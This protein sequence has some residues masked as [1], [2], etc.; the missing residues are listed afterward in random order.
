[1]VISLEMEL[2][3]VL[4]GWVVP[5]LLG[6]FLLLI[7]TPE[8]HDQVYYEN[9]KRTCATVFLLFGVEILCQWLMR[10][11]EINNPILSVST[12]LFTFCLATQLLAMGYCAM[13]WPNSIDKRQQGI[14]V[15]TLMTFTS[16]LVI[17]YFLLP[18]RWQVWGLML[19]CVLLFFLT[20]CAIYSCVVIYRR[21]IKNLRTYYS[22]VVENMIRWMPGV[23]AGILIFLLSAPFIIWLPR[24]V[25]VYQ[26]TLG[27]IM[28]I[29]TFIC[30]LNFSSTYRS[31]A[32]ARDENA[33]AVEEEM[34]AAGDDEEVQASS[35]HSTLSDS[36]LE[37]LQVKEERW[38]AL[39][40]YR[41]C[42][43]TIEQAARE[44]GT[45][46]SYLSRY[47]NEVKHMTF[48]EWVAQ[49][50]IRDAQSMMLN[51]PN[52]SIEQIAGLVGFSS[53]STFS[54]TFKKLVG[55]SPNRWRNQQ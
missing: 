51:N 32:V 12:Y 41:T 52:K 19:C 28:F 30:M 33:M 31:L 18:R 11:L 44:M 35:Q 27:I 40:G 9:G 22:D 23:G 37:V 14:A 45:N 43:I 5:L 10:K 17:N 13:L 29:Y 53:T 47:L 42:G 24:W 21:A 3:I 48:Y 7:K 55:V 36:L 49:L 39:G 38:R 20:C 46:R 2:N 16:L 15:V 1:M 6:L 34:A 26:V 25:G 8:T 50:R 54:S 4:I